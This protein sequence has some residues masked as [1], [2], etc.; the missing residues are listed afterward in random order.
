MIKI[1]KILFF[2]IIITHIAIV[3][4]VWANDDVKSFEELT[5]EFYDL[6]VDNEVK[7]NMYGIK[8]IPWLDSRHAKIKQIDSIYIQRIDFLEKESPLHRAERLYWSMITSKK[9][10]NK[11]FVLQTY[12]E[13]A[14]SIGY[15]NPIMNNLLSIYIAY[16]FY[17][18]NFHDEILE[19]YDEVIKGYEKEI[20][21]PLFNETNIKNLL[22]NSKKESYKIFYLNPNALLDY[23]IRIHRDRKDFK[24]AEEYAKKSLFF[25]KNLKLY[26]NPDTYRSYSEAG[27]L[28][29]IKDILVNLQQYEDLISVFEEMYNYYQK[30]PLK[31]NLIYQKHFYDIAYNN[32]ISFLRQYSGLECKRGKVKLC[33]SLAKEST[34]LAEKKYGLYSEEVK[35]GYGLGYDIYFAGD[36]KIAQEFILKSIEIDMKI[37]NKYN[38]SKHLNILDRALWVTLWPSIKLEDELIKIYKFMD[39]YNLNQGVGR[40]IFLAYHATLHMKY[41]RYEKALAETQEAL[42]IISNKKE[43]AADVGIFFIDQLED[44]LQKL[45]DYNSALKLSKIKLEMLEKKNEK[46]P[47]WV[48]G[49]LNIAYQK[50]SIA[51]NLRA[52]KKYIPAIK[53][54]IEATKI[55][56]K[57]PEYTIAIDAHIGLAETLYVYTE[58]VSEKLEMELLEY[59]FDI[60]ENKK[61]IVKKKPESFWP[62]EN[63]YFDF[64]TI[65]IKLY[66]RLLFDSKAMSLAWDS[67]TGFDKSKLD[68]DEYKK[69]TKVENEYNKILEKLINNK[70]ITKNKREFYKYQK[71]LAEFSEL[72]AKDVFVG[73]NEEEKKIQ[74]S[75]FMDTLY[76][77][78][79]KNYKIGKIYSVRNEDYFTISLP[80]TEDWPALVYNFDRYKNKIKE[81]YNKDEIFFYHSKNE[82]HI[83]K[84]IK[85]LQ[86]TNK[87]SSAKYLRF[88]SQRV[89]SKKNPLLIKKKQDLAFQINSMNKE[90]LNLHTYTLKTGINNSEKSKLLK[91]EIEK[92]NNDLKKIERKIY[93]ENPEFRYLLNPDPLNIKQIQMLLDDDEMIRKYSASKRW[94][95][96]M[97]ITKNDTNFYFRLKGKKTDI[98]IDEFLLNTKKI[99]VKKFDLITSSILFNLLFP[100]EEIPKNIKKITVIADNFVKNIPFSI[101]VKDLDKMDYYQKNKN[102]AYKDEN[103]N[104]NLNSLKSANWLIK[105]YSIRRLPSINALKLLKKNQKFLKARNEFVGFA[106]PDLPKNKKNF[107]DYLKI[108]GLK[109][110]S[111]NNYNIRG[112]V[113]DDTSII[114]KKYYRLPTSKKELIKISKSLK[115]YKIQNYFGKEMTETKIKTLDLSKSKI[116]LFSTHAEIRGNIKGMDEPFLVTTP[117]VQGSELDD[118]LLTATEISQLN[119]NADWVIL[120]ACNTG[121][122]DTNTK[123]NFPGLSSAFLYA[124]AKSL[125]VSYWPVED[126]SA[127]SI[128]T[129]MFKKIKKNP[130]IYKTDALRLSVLEFIKNS[131]GEY[132]HPAYWGPFYIVGSHKSI[133]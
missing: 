38:Y 61:E 122:D 101:L 68:Q 113:L 105:D 118:G 1:L 12:K 4:S 106:D 24:K 46:N 27:R 29:T 5:E 90:V 87:Q 110:N 36:I 65:Y 71:L 15:N 84:S 51:F 112:G 26:K 54:Y 81:I 13:I 55:I 44:N 109:R 69:Y 43:L 93:Q 7:M 50:T 86:I 103:I 34:N 16:P 131:K 130:K 42:E 99:P 95:Y 120:S 111:S 98:L 125:L 108:S 59:A 64:L 83:N 97:T 58:Q 11:D 32:Y 18:D 78:F 23:V 57:Y 91:K 79:T 67:E 62:A 123:N 33:V 73:L 37:A 80:T 60:L 89:S 75:F 74:E 124:G 127:T 94:A 35:A 129:A 2:F 20:G 53:N 115:N 30:N 39:Q 104:E 107:N 25:M 76:D 52:L 77:E 126:Y 121:I 114:A 40:A 102:K 132:S 9:Y 63:A 116:I 88:L 82:E 48:M 96:I 92:K 19:I 49:H 66:N 28:Y 70:L 128:T 21:F 45:K 72:S 119:L 133:N 14:R 117:P 10:T 85:L 6:I 31:E 56:D 8:S 100:E 3:N 47:H 41:N 17:R 22:N